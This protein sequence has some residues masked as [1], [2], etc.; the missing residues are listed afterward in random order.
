M[1]AKLYKFSIQLRPPIRSDA[2]KFGAAKLHDH[3]SERGPVSESINELLTVWE[4]KSWSNF[5]KVYGC[6]IMSYQKGKAHI[7]APF[8]RQSFPK[9]AARRAVQA[10]TLRH[11][12]KS[13]TN[14]NLIIR[15]LFVDHVKIYEPFFIFDLYSSLHIVEVWAPAQRKRML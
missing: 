4:K 2:K 5:I 7:F 15:Y 14:T 3:P 1:M 13:R 8:G 10:S 11:K 6:Y 12:L 9:E